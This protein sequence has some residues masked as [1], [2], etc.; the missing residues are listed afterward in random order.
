MALLVLRIWAERWAPWASLYATGP[1]LM[2][3]AALSKAMFPP[4]ELREKIPSGS[5]GGEFNP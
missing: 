1:G 4:R 5:P 2:Q 3:P